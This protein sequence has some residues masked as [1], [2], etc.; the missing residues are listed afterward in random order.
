MKKITADKFKQRCLTIIEQVDAEGI[1]ITKNGKPVAKLVPAPSGP[2]DWIGSMK[3]KIK[4]KGDISSTGL[5][6]DAE[7]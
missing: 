3:G 4:V 7:S 6:W 1:V 5:R 2:A